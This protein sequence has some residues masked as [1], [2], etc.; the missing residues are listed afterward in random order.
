MHSRFGS[1]GRGLCPAPEERAD[2]AV[3]TMLPS[4]SFPGTTAVHA[5]EQRHEDEV[6]RL[7]LFLL[8]H[9]HD[10]LN[11]TSD[12]SITDMAIATAFYCYAIFFPRVQGACSVSRRGWMFGEPESERWPSRIRS[13]D[14]SRKSCCSLLTALI[15]SDMTSLVQLVCL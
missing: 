15:S 6:I 3:A 14:W 13:A 1:L 12:A 7:R 2:R 5:R 9:D 10:K 11:Q 8:D 4:N